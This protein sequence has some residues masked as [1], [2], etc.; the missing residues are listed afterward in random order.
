MLVIQ[1]VDIEL[2]V[3]QFIVIQF[4]VVEL[5]VFIESRARPQQ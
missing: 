3:I 5:F 2:D 1:F 4:I